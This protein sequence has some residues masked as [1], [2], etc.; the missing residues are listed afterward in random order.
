VAP[1]GT[2]IR[3]GFASIL[4]QEEIHLKEVYSGTPQS[5][6]KESQI[7]PFSH[8]YVSSPVEQSLLNLILEAISET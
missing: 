4:G 2:F 1:N 3:H 8:L 6:P 7:I 5:L